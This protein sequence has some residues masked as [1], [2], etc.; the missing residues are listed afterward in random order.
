[1]QNTI[2]FKSLL[3]CNLLIFLLTGTT[4]SYPYHGHQGNVTGGNYDS[5]TGS[6]TI[7]DNAGESSGPIGYNP[8]LQV[9]DLESKWVY[10]SLA[11][12]NFPGGSINMFYQG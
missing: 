9:L 7:M 3:F 6:L 8:V 4:V 12:P 5:T 11:G 10:G 2:K 1:M